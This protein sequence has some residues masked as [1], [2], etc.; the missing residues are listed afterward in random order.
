MVRKYIMHMK[1]DFKM[2]KE[3]IKKELLNDLGKDYSNITIDNTIDLNNGEI[4]LEGELYLNGITVD[5]TITTFNQKIDKDYLKF[6][7][8]QCGEFVTWYTLDVEDCICNDCKEYNEENG[9]D[10]V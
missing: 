2:N 5:Y 8:E 9:Y 10:F 7:C 1:G 6:R 4:Y 3:L